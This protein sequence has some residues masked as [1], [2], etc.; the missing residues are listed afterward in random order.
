[1]YKKEVSR[2]IDRERK[3]KRSA[4]AWQINKHEINQIF[5]ICFDINF[6][7]GNFKNGGVGE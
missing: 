5:D 2:K 1:M 3:R 6:G 7:S 4:K